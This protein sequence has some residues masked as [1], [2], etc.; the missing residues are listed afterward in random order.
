MLRL[1][2]GD[3]ESRDAR[4]AALDVGNLW[5]GG[6]APG[7]GAGRRPWSLGR[8]GLGEPHVEAAIWV[9]LRRHPVCRVDGGVSQGETLARWAATA[10]SED[11]VP[12]LKVS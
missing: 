5:V 8:R 10:T 9:L 11:I 1:Q 12:F 7:S 4:A 3:A 2:F 6:R